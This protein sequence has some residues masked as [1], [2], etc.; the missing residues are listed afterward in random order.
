[1]P[2]YLIEVHHASAREGCIKALHALEQ[3]GSHFVTHA[4]FGC[5]DGVHCGWLAVEADDRDM[6]SAIVPP[7]FRS[8][9][10]VVELCKFSREDIHRMM[11]QH[12]G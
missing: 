1:V 4:D 12:G 8:G 3:S 6:A 2:H 9:A 5:K 10:R 7:E 11:E